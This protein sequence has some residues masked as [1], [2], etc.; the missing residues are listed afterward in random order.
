MEYCKS[1]SLVNIRI[2]QLNHKNCPISII[3]TFIIGFLVINETCLQ[4]CCSSFLREIKK[5]RL[6]ILISVYVKL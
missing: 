6:H 1:R 3:V 2:S 4:V 5:G